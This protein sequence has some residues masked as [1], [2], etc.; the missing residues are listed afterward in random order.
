MTHEGNKAWNQGFM[1]GYNGVT[2]VAGKGA[3][4]DNGYNRG[5][6]TAQR[7]EATLTWSSIV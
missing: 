5:Y 1:D 4:Y 2:H 3:D 6:E 7:Q